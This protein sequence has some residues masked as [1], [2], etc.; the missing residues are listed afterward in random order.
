MIVFIKACVFVY[1]IGMTGIGDIYLCIYICIL[2]PLCSIYYCYLY[3]FNYSGV[4]FYMVINISFI[5]YFSNN[6]CI[7][8][9]NFI[10]T[11]ILLFIFVYKCVLYIN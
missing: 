7:Y 5:F 6:C 9:L 11:Y 10:C 1:L 8:N 2:V 3:I 4:L